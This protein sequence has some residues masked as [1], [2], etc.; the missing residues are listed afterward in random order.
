MLR[1]IVVLMLVF[2]GCAQNTDLFTRQTPST[3]ITVNIHNGPETPSVGSY[4][5][6]DAPSVPSTQPVSVADVTDED[7]SQV[8]TLPSGTRNQVVKVWIDNGVTMA[9]DATSES[10]Q[11]IKAEVQAMLQVMYGLLSQ[12]QSTP[13]SAL[14]G[15]ADSQG[16]S[17]EATPSVTVNVAVPATQPDG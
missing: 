3:P 17:Q 14:G 2:G 13:A 15:D 12:L 9:S 10:V 11:D 5:D 6:A 16:G 7:G 8:V 1:W 4:T